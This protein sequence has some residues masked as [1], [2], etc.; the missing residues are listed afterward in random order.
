MEKSGLRV[1]SHVEIARWYQGVR[2][3][4][5]CRID[6]LDEDA[7]TIELKSVE[8]IHPLHKA[9][10]LSC[11]KLSGTKVGI[12]INPNVDR[13]KNGVTRMANGL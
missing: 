1:S 4:I 6:L 3:D 10:L 11:L 5:G 2:I 13:L 9:Q 12:L 7:V 8:C